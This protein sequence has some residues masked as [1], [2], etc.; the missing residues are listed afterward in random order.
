MLVELD[1]P[2]LTG[3]DNRIFPRR[4]SSVRCRV[5]DGEVERF[6]RLANISFGGARVIT[7]SPPNAGTEVAIRFKL[8]HDG[9]AIESRARVVW[10]VEGFRGRGGMMGV[11]FESL[12]DEAEVARYVKQ[13]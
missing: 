12:S 4:P 10:R 6:T 3:S 11:A 5:S 7:A 9:P 8:R 13:G 1:S 2:R